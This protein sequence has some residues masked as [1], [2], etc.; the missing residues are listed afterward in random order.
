MVTDLYDKRTAKEKLLDFI[1]AKKIV[2]THEVIAWGVANHSNRADRDARL[3]ANQGFI[4]RMSPE[5]K[6]QVFYHNNFKEE[7]WELCPGKNDYLK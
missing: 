4:E 7:V 1:R 5:R 6:R 3:L 2:F